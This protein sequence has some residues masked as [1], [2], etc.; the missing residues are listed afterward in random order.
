MFKKIVVVAGIIVSS[1]AF[2]QAE[3]FAGA[4]VGINVG[5]NNEYVSFSGTKLGNYNYSYNINGSY[6][7]ALSD[8]TTLALGMT[9]D[10]GDS[11]AINATTMSN[12]ADN[13]NPMLVKSH[14]SI[15]IEP[16]YA[17]TESNLA[18]LKLA[19]HRANSYQSGLSIDKVITGTGYGIGTKYL[20]SKNTFFSLEIQKTTYN[21]YTYE[22][23]SVTHTSTL[24]SVGF[25]YKF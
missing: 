2:A 25:G 4:S 6:T 12:L 24:G 20:M 5:F 21:S 22:T 15:N 9:Y 14:Y 11:T 18:Y 16:G 17:L 1:S 7:F 23:N 10:L 8:Q 19:Y 3:K 13:S